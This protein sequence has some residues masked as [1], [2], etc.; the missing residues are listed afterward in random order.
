MKNKIIHTSEIHVLAHLL[1]TSDMAVI[2]YDPGS[3]LCV[4]DEHLFPTATRLKELMVMAIHKGAEKLC[5][6][7][8][9]NETLDFAEADF[10]IEFNTDKKYENKNKINWRYIAN[11]NGTMRWLYP[12][13]ISKPWFLSFYNFNYWKAACYKLI[14]KALFAIRITKPISNGT[15]TIHAGQS[16]SV[17]ELLLINSHSNNEY[18]IFSGTPGPNRKIILA[19]A[20]NNKISN[21]FK[22]SLNNRSRGNIYNEY[23]ALRKLQSLH[24][25]CFVIPETDLI[26]EQTISVS[27]IKPAHSSNQS[28]F[29]EKHALFL[30][31]LYAS[32]HGCKYFK[33]LRIC[34]DTQR[35]LQ[36]IAGH[37]KLK[38]TSFAVELFD[39]L[40]SLHDSLA[41]ENPFI[42]AAINHGDFTRWNCYQDEKKIYVYDWELSHDEMPLLHDLFHFV[43]QGAVYS[44]NANAAEIQHQ[45]H[46]AFERDEVK[47]IVREF[48]IDAALH[49]QLYLLHNAS[50]YLHMYL[51]QQTLHK[52][53]FWLFKIWSSLLPDENPKIK[54]P[55]HRK[56]FME[57]FFQFMS[58]KKYV[59]L[60]N[61]GKVIDDLSYTSD[62]DLLVTK[63]DISVIIQWAKRDA[64]IQKVKCVRKSFMTTIQ[65]FF[66]DHSFLSIDLL[67]A[68]HRKSI[69]YIDA[70]WLLKNAIVENGVKILP[71]EYDY[72]YIFLFYQINFSGVPQK[73]ADHFKDLNQPKE[74]KILEVLKTSTGIGFMSISETFLFSN[75]VRS[76]IFSFLKK[77]ERNNMLRRGVRGFR[78]WI[79]LITEFAQ[80]KGM[81]LTFSGVDGA[82]KSTIL[83]EVKEMLEKKYRKKVIVIRHRPSMLP[84]LSAWKYGKEAA[85]Q[86]CIDSLPR[87]G[88]NKNLLSS[89]LRFGY[90]YADYLFGQ[91]IVYTKYILRGYIVLYDRYYF[92][93]IVDSKRSNININK[94][95]IKSLYRLVY[96]PELNVFLYAQPDVILKRKK[97]LSAEDIIQLTA[98]YKYL[99]NQLGDELQ[100]ICIE[101]IDKAETVN[102][103]E[104]AFI[105]LN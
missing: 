50:Y 101:N 97:E 76:S 5:V 18:A 66:S 37:P 92:D 10:I 3:A 23:K 15:V 89:L 53:A 59:L 49:L 68:F 75:E 30:N 36:K 57:S 44:S 1:A 77:K 100:Y 26:D 95:F 12:P 67:S 93:F 41:N 61:T 2:V 55:S 62:I 35:L 8:N 102:R 99:F 38:V 56:Q 81:M 28:G 104:H 58:D 21:F 51:D 63:A 96:K 19:V 46:E 47:K 86:R 105:Q 29:G 88:N 71:A 90:Y 83:Q 78:Y 25:D 60:K 48:G 91:F 43:I 20:D 79:D 82:G 6:I 103:I 4:D 32:S 54:R 27:N 7:N 33:E 94:S 14:V 73:Y 52:E 42:P 22:I 70:D 13:G 24:S 17:E 98:N 72:L 64:T 87:K 40:Q 31:Q 84:I 34:A 80:N 65:I 11:P 74:H 9:S 85:E 39:K 69:Q 45:L 16:V